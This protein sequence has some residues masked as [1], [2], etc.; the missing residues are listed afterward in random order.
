MDL[1]DTMKIELDLI[2]K[3]R[4]LSLLRPL[5]MLIVF[6]P[7][8]FLENSYLTEIG[9]LG[10]WSAFWLI[11]FF[12]QVGLIKRYK[13]IGK[14]ILHPIS[15][16]IKEGSNSSI[17]NLDNNLKI[18]M[19]YNG[20]RGQLANY[21]SPFQLPIFTKEGIGSLLIKV[22][23]KKAKYFFV[24]NKDCTRKLI[25]LFS[26]YEKLAKKADLRID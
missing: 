6:L 23:E 4:I 15:I 9:I 10:K 13:K 11:V 1:I 5:N 8:F 25:V 24:S 14:I 16:N 7:V 2:E 12:M 22:P 18:E 26:E 17:F 19:E 21:K 20:Y 3:N